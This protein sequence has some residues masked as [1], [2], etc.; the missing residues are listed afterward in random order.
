MPA[1]STRLLLLS[2]LASLVLVTTAEAQKKPLKAPKPPIVAIVDVQEVLSKAEASRKAKK[3]IE[4]RRAIYEKELD[5]HKK[6]L[7]A[8]RDKLKKQ[9]AVL[10]PEALEKR[11]RDLEKRFAEVRKQTDERRQILNKALNTAMGTLRKEM[12]FAVAEVMKAKGVEMT[13]PR[14]AV[15][16]FDDRLNISNEV[17][18]ALNKR[19]PQVKLPLK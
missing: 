8:G 5:K 19:L 2:V 12:G 6:S 11:R 13:L 10:S 3:A 18:A 7:K 16:V 9:Q 14:S 17:L 4:A 15:L 1:K